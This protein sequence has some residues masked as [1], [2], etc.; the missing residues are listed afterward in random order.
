V[1]WRRI[2][3][4][5]LWFAEI[6]ARV[7]VQTVAARG[8]DGRGSRRRSRRAGAFGRDRRKRPLKLISDL[9]KESTGVLVDET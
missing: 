6:E 2:Y 8:A 4:P 3:L 7:K 1:S 5:S 9:G